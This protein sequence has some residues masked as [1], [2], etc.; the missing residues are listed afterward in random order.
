MGWLGLHPWWPLRGCQG[1]P[2]GLQDFTQSRLH[3]GLLRLLIILHIFRLLLC[4]YFLRCLGT[5]EEGDDGLSLCE[6]ELLP[7]SPLQLHSHPTLSLNLLLL[8]FL[9]FLAGIPSPLNLIGDDILR[10]LSSLGSTSLIVA[11][12]R[13]ASLDDEI[14]L[15]RFRLVSLWLHFEFKQIN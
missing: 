6:C 9:H 5:L 12:Q 2:I 11:D 8:L 1:R 14:G 4:V 7:L 10:E 3:R 13:L 15:P